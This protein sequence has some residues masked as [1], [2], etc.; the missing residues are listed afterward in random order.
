ML[1]WNT[2]TIEIHIPEYYWQIGEY[3]LELVYAIV[4]K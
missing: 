4:F 3:Q 1:T 2:L